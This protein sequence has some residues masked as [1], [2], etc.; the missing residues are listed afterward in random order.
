MN[1]TKPEVFIAGI[2]CGVVFTA[3]LKA[4][5]EIAGWCCE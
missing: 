2:W 1:W 5:L 3:A 4:G